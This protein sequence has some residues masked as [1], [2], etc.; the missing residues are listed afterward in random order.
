MI[1]RLVKTSYWFTKTLNKKTAKIDYNFLKNI[2]SKTKL[3]KV[4]VN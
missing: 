1:L 3:L 4:K 2:Y